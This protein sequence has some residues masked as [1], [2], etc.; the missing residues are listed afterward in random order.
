[1]LNS[2]LLIFNK[3]SFLSTNIQEKS[4]ARNSL[5]MP[6]FASRSVTHTSGGLFAKAV[7]ILAA[8]KPNNNLV[9]VACAGV[10]VSA[11]TRGTIS[12]RARKN[13]PKTRSRSFTSRFSRVNF[14]AESVALKLFFGFEIF[15]RP[16]IYG[17]L[18]MIYAATENHRCSRAPVNFTSALDECDIATV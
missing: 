16:V 2:K 15:I 17:H 8:D 14:Y 13:E 5:N 4:T 6:I 3:A 1:M 11:V 12:T 7:N 9:H 18:F 10:H